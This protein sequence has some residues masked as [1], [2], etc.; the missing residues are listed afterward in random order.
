VSALP[1]PPA[2]RPVPAVVIRATALFLA[3]LVPLQFVVVVVRDDVGATTFVTVT[4]RWAVS[5][6]Q[7]LEWVTLVLA[8][9]HGCLVL[10]AAIGRRVPGPRM[11]RVLATGVGLLAVV[12][13]AGVTWSMLTYS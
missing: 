6:W 1:E 11:R 7:G 8:L 13:G 3:V 10:R 4:D 12:L 2:A 9:V 5:W